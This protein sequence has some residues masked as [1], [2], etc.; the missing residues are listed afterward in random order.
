MKAKKLI[1]KCANSQVYNRLKRKLL[2]NED[3]RCSFCPI[4]GGENAT[5]KG[6]H[7]VKKPKYKDK[8]K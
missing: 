6:K 7:G 8:R 3:G 2:A 1:K 4:H 5:R